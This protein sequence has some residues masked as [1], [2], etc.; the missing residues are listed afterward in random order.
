MIEILLGFL[1]LMFSI[2]TISFALAESI[3]TEGDNNES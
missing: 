2:A 3:F 1:F